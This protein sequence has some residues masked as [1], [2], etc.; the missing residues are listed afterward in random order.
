MSLGSPNITTTVSGV[1]YTYTPTKNVGEYV[2]TNSPAG[3]PILLQ[4]K[5]TNTASKSRFVAEA[6]WQV[7]AVGT[8]PEKT[9]RVYVVV[10]AP[11]HPDVTDAI[12][13]TKVK[14]LSF[15]LS[16]A[17]IAKLKRDEV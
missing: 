14:E 9:A 5:S 17:N 15:L 16:A 2:F 12:I 8:Q 10:D 1:N 7:A 3:L 11:D 4:L 13:E 6:R